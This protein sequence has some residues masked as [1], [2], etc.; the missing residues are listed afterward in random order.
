M[1]AL[2]QGFLVVYSYGT[3]IRSAYSQ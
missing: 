3:D 1:T 2:T